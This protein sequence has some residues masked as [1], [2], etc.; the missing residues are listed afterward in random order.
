MDDQIVYT[1]MPNLKH[2]PKN[3]E[4]NKIFGA[5]HGVTEIHV[6]IS[7][8]ELGAKKDK[9]IPIHIT[10]PC[11]ARFTKKKVNLD[12]SIGFDKS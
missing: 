8:T 12:S 4:A 6:T 7:Q 10:R 2:L 3:E 9:K 1:N 5:L 11:F